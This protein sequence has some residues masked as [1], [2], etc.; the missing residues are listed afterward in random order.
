M[1]AETGVT[2]WWPGGNAGVRFQDCLL[3]SFYNPG[4][5]PGVASMLPPFW[6]CNLTLLGPCIPRDPCHIQ[7]VH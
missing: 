5:N 3:L 4:S 1:G 6:K 7:Q 2:C